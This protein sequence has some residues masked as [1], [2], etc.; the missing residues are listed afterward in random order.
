MR[1]HD[2]V[3]RQS[4]E[5]FSNGISRHRFLDKAA[6][7]VFA[8]AAALALGEIGVRTVSA[9]GCQTGG[10]GGY[11]YCG[12]CNPVSNGGRPC[13][14]CPN[15]GGPQQC[16]TGMTICGRGCSYCSYDSGYWCCTGGNCGSTISYCTDCVYPYGTCSSA[17]TCSSHS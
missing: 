7:T 3:V 5:Q 17:C 6:K 11:G 14:G 8:A 1:D 9:Q 13:N 15:P 10:S 2:G 4:F 12:C 16:P